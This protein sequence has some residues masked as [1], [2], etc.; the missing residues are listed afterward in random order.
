MS[1]NMSLLWVSSYISR[2]AE[3]LHENPKMGIFN[4]SKKFSENFMNEIL[5]SKRQWGISNAI[6]IKISSNSRF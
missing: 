4:K 6:Y 2:K 3:I 1:N 5:E